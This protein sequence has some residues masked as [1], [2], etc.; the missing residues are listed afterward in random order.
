MGMWLM[1]VSAWSSSRWTESTFLCRAAD[2]LT[3]NTCSKTEEKHETDYLLTFRPVWVQSPLPLEAVWAESGQPLPHW[4]TAAAT[5]GESESTC[6]ARSSSAAG[7]HTQ[8]PFH[9]PAHRSVWPAGKRLYPA[10]ED[11]ITATWSRPLLV[12]LCQ[13]SSRNL[14]F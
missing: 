13:I 4:P 7:S 14:H 3:R 11:G 9:P 10:W 8:S 6:P 5:P 12:K 1:G 2:F